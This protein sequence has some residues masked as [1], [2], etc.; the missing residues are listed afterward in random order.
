[1]DPRR[2]IEQQ[3]RKHQKE[4]SARKIADALNRFGRFDHKSIPQDLIK[5][6]VQENKDVADHFGIR[7]A[8]TLEPRF[9]LRRRKISVNEDRTRDDHHNSEKDHRNKERSV[10]V[11][12]VFFKELKNE[13]I[14]DRKDDR[15]QTKVK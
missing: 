6:H 12:C 9:A 14:G 1:K 7:A 3:R 15:C 8:E 10:I 11:A 4:K 5:D 13:R 2:K